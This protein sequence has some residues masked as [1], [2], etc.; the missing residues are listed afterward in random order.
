MVTKTTRWSPDTCGCSVEFTWDTD[1]PAENRTHSFKRV[2]ISCPAHEGLPTGQAMYDSVSEENPRKN[3]ILDAFVQATD[4]I[5]ESY[6]DD[7]GQPARKL[8]DNLDFEYVFTGT[9]PD[10]II[11]VEFKD[12]LAGNTKVDIKKADSD[13]IKSDLETKAGIDITKVVI[14]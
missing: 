3:K 6:T 1:D 9:A 13:K 12:K 5:G 2:V 11:E 14:K 7:N 10:R 8:K 4:D